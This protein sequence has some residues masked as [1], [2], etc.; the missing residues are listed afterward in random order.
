[1]PAT[2][3]HTVS[4]AGLQAELQQLGIDPAT[5]DFSRGLRAAAVYLASMSKRNFAGSHE[6]DGAPWPPLK[7]PSRRPGGRSA[8]PLVDKGILMASVSASGGGGAVRDV[9]TRSLEFGTNVSYAGF[10]QYGTRTIPARRFLGITEAMAKRIE[11]LIADDVVR[12]MGFGTE[13]EH[14]G[15]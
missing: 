1:M 2:A 3:S 7:N 11:E 10:H 6:P 5:V 4:L 15:A 8:R 12:Q 9:T 14:G 13:G